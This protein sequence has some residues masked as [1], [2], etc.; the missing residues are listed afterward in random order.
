MV[1][2]AC[3]DV[4]DNKKRRVYSVMYTR[5]QQLCALCAYGKADAPLIGRKLG[6]QLLFPRTRRTATSEGGRQSD[7]APLVKFP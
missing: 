2:R 5:E 3:I 6:V 1:L 7:H 4:I